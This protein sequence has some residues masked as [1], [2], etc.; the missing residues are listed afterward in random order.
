MQPL[1]P[2]R[3]AIVVMGVSGSGK[4][5]V[6]AMLAERMHAIF[7]E[8]DEFHPPANRRKMS[9][10]T[11]LTDDDRWPWL[12][13]VGAALGQAVRRDGVAVA[14]CSALRKAYR[15]ALTRAA[16]APV[17]FACLRLDRD[18]LTTRMA[19]RGGHFMPVS[20]LESQ[21][22]TLESPE[23]SENA[24]VLDAV[25]SPQQIVDRILGELRRPLD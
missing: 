13:A 4:S 21:L 6:G 17:F 8:G 14:A 10:G 9:T 24:F 22:A 1:R 12:D 18:A 23:P 11:P 3:R 5:T 2:D 19:Q 16:D 7:I 25:D 20:L 15:E